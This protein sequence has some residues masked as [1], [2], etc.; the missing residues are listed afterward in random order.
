MVSGRRPSTTCLCTDSTCFRVAVDRLGSMAIGV[1]GLFALLTLAGLVYTGLALWAA[2]RF[3]RARRD[4]APGAF[5][6][7][8]SL[9]KPLKGVDARIMDALRSH[10]RQVYAGELEIVFGVSSEDDPAVALVRALEAEFP[11]V[12]MRLV[13]SAGRLGTNGK[14]SNLV[15]ML[16]AARHAFVIVNDSDIE[17]SREYVARVIGPFAGER[18]GMVTTL[19][20]GRTSRARVP[21]WSKLEALGIA[22]DFAPG[23]L[24][25]RMLEG[26]I[27]FGLG[28]TLAMR[29]E[30]LAAAGGFEA[31]VDTLA[32]DYE[33][34]RRVA[35][36]GYKVELSGEVVKTTV[37]D[38]R[39]RGFLE[40]QMRWA[41]TV[42][43]SRRWGY[44]GL[45]VTFCVPWALLT[46]VASGLALW[47][48]TLL[49]LVLLARVTLALSVGV[50]VL[51][52][53]QVLQDLWLLPVRDCLA[54]YFWAWSF[55]GD[56]V[57][58]RGERFRLRDGRLEQM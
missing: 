20:R 48:F 50:G 7:G 33:L 49:S 37:P 25:A 10:C 55:A 41:R 8:V 26:G 44:A 27:R 57:V 28:S 46:W 4:D 14:V 3:A 22:T 45:G 12:P 53:E 23:V 29:R 21:V 35:A 43:D 24:T 11:D 58:W 54:L 39:W 47:S 42:R 34:G 15:Q 40:H 19:Y 52:D 1:E 36:A 32:D 30:A 17:V 16:P 56:T 51:R 5:A 38:Y 18:V 2:R 9:L 31:M 13:V 6:P